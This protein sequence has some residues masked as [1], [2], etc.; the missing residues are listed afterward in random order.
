[1]GTDEFHFLLGKYVDQRA[2]RL[3]LKDHSVLATAYRLGIPVF[4]SSPGD[5]SIGMNVAAMSL[6]E[7]S[8]QFDVNQVVNQTASIVYHAK[9]SR[10]KSSVFILGGGS[11]KN[12]ILQTEPQIQEVMGPRIRPRP[13]SNHRCQTRHR[14]PQWSHSCRG[15]QLG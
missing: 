13:S 2:K 5:S 14:R 6:R 11:P 8:L 3:G 10:K 7:S 15:G 9:K 4:T 1:M 12:F